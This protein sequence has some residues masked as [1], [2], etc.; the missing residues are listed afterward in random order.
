[1]SVNISPRQLRQPN[2]VDDV[3]SA[4]AESGL[5]SASL[6]LEI[7]ENVLIEDTEG[8]IETLHRLKA[9]GVSLAIDDFGTGYSSLSYLSRLPVDVLKIDRAFV[10]KVVGDSEESAVAQAI[11]KLAATFRLSTVA[12][13]V[14]LAEQAGRLRDLGGHL[15][16]GF[17]FAPPL[18][19]EDLEALLS[20]ER[21]APEEERWPG[22]RTST[23]SPQARP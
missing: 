4:L 22:E 7:T 11:L 16:Q 8:T 13:G 17:Y 14:E 21:P 18:P 12:E 6:V 2:L 1:V 15:G 20:R 23:L 9:L 5:D 10:A 19:V 3:T